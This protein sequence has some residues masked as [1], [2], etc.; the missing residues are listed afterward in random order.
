MTIV[1]TASSDFDLC[2]SIVKS[3]FDFGL[4]AVVKELL[5]IVPSIVWRMSLYDIKRSTRHTGHR[6]T[7][8]I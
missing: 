8:N 4:S 1:N 3:V 5:L 6:S 2:S 7:E